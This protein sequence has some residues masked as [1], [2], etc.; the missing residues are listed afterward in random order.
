MSRDGGGPGPAAAVTHADFEEALRR[1][2]AGSASSAA[3]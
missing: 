1:L 2:R 3:T